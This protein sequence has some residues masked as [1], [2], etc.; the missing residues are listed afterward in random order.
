VRKC[1]SWQACVVGRALDGRIWE[2]HSPSA[3]VR[4]QMSHTSF[5]FVALKLPRWHT[6]LALALCT[7]FGTDVG[8]V[9]GTIR[10]RPITLSGGKPSLCQQ[11][12][13]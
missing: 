5:F 9:Y 6:L 7:R 13:A 3:G 10:L 4:F 8:K 12:K 2:S 11:T 1:H